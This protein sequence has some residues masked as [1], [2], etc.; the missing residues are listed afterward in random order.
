MLKSPK[1]PT[2][3]MEYF[4]QDTGVDPNSVGLRTAD[5]AYEYSQNLRRSGQQ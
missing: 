5:E 3:W 4:M 2:A 1:H